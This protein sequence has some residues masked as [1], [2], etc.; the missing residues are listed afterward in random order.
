MRAFQNGA[1][2]AGAFQG[3][4]AVIAAALD[5]LRIRRRRRR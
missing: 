5:W 2:Q 3:V 4:G 1:F